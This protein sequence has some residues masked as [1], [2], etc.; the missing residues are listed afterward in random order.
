MIINVAVRKYS[1]DLKLVTHIPSIEIEIL[2]MYLLDKN[3]NWLH[4]NYNSVFSKIK[5]LETIVN[6][7]ATN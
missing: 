7:R 4:L 5:E 1:N 2:I 6:K 3:V